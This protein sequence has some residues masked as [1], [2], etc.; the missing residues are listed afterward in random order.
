MNKS[1]K[2]WIAFSSIEQIDSTFIQRLYNYFGDIETAFKANLKDLSDIDGLSIKKA[3]K[4]VEL[5][6]KINL[7][8]VYNVVADRGI[9]FLTLEDENYPAM[10]K[11]IYNI[12]LYTGRYPNIKCFFM[13]ETNKNT[14]T[15][16][17]NCAII[18][19][20]D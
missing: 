6:D 7:D 12:T 20:S 4:F 2:Y 16:T 5:R 14:L 9:N 18:L 17:T 10:L 19:I 3:E 1:S 8:S 13:F 11:N 15:I